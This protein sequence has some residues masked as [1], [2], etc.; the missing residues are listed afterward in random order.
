MQHPFRPKPY[1]QGFNASPN[2]ES[3]LPQL[4]RA[5]TPP[6]RVVPVRPDPA[7]TTTARTRQLPDPGQGLSLGHLVRGTMELLLAGT[8]LLLRLVRSVS[9]KPAGSAY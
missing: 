9:M 8:S 5:L 1:R 3:T 2:T 4:E 6:N 7:A